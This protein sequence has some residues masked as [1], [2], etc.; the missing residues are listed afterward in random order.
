MTKSHVAALI[1]AASF[2]A[3]PAH[4]AVSFGSTPSPAAT[5]APVAM[6]IE[7]TMEAPPQPLPHLMRRLLVAMLRANGGARVERTLAVVSSTGV[8]VTRQ[9]GI[10]RARRQAVAA[11]QAEYGADSSV[12]RPRFEVEEFGPIVAVDGFWLCTGDEADAYHRALPPRRD[13]RLAGT[14]SEASSYCSS[15]YGLTSQPVNDSAAVGA[16]QQWSGISDFH[17]SD[18]NAWAEPTTNFPPGGSTVRASDV[19][20]LIDSTVCIFGNSCGTGV[21]EYFHGMLDTSGNPF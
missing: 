19:L 4:A 5:P 20:D 16:R 1:L 9:Q 12:S 2:A 3:G 6:N 15:A 10:N 8:G 18:P 13:G 11:C 21:H 17:C 14:W 7:V